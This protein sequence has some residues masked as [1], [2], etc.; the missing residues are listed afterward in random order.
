MALLSACSGSS[1]FDQSKYE[2]KYEGRSV[3]QL[4]EII[5]N[6]PDN[7]EAITQLAREYMELGW[8]NEAKKEEYWRLGFDN[9]M[10]AAQKGHVV[11]QYD[12]GVNYVNGWGVEKDAKKAYEWWTKS[13]AEGYPSAEAAIGKCYFNGW[14]VK[15]NYEE[16]CKWWKKA[17]EANDLDG[18]IALAYSYFS[19]TGVA[20]DDE[21]GLEWAQKAA[22]MGDDSALAYYKYVVIGEEN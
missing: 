11:A 12:V 17:A 5:N 20:K 1:R 22:D 19:G 3:E 8:A 15:K 18:M 9:F 16:A 10:K 2:K 13:A 21:K 4:Q 14:G 6:N 7:L